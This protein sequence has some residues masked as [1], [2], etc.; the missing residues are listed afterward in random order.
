MASFHD[1]PVFLL[2]LEKNDAKLHRLEHDLLLTHSAPAIM[3]TSPDNPQDKS[4]YLVPGEL[5]IW[6]W[7]GF[8][9]FFPP[10][11]EADEKEASSNILHGCSSVCAYLSSMSK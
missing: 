4:T 5:I 10:N 7:L 8:D 1:N 11:Q 2:Q 6:R 9:R 3:R